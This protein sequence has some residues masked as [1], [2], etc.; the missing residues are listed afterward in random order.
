MDAFTDHDLLLLIHTLK[1]AQNSIRLYESLV[2]EFGTA[3][4][5]LGYVAALR[6]DRA[7][8]CGS[9]VK[10]TDATGEPAGHKVMVR[11]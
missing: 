5:L 8:R 6:T 7:H 9:V 10:G 11:P 4:V 1:D 3:E 2:A